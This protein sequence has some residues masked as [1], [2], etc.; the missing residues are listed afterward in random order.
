MDPRATTPRAPKGLAVALAVILIVAAGFLLTRGGDD[1]PSSAQT[2]E[3]TSPAGGG[4]VTAAAVC[5]EIAPDLV[6]RTDSFQRTAD[7]VRTDAEAL[8][9]NGDTETSAKAYELADTLDALADA[10]E[11]Q[12]DTSELLG[13]LTTQ[14]DA[15]GC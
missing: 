7:A 14:L 5:G 15:L 2:S 11:S 1:E 10:T 12:T 4:D 6:M 3:P 13:D 9:A 8:Q